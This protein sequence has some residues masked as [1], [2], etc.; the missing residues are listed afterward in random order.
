MGEKATGWGHVCRVLLCG[1]HTRLPPR[2][3]AGRGGQE[4]PANPARSVYSARAAPPPHHL[5]FHF[6]LRN[7]AHELKGEMCLRHFRDRVWQPFFVCTNN[8]KLTIIMM[9]EHLGLGT[10]IV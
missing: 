3:S 4:S 7:M 10:F 8:L 1:R 2:C 5:V 6:Y 9:F